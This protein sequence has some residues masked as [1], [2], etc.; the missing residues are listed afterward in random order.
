[1]LLKFNNAL[2]LSLVAV[3]MAGCTSPM[4]RL[5][6]PA[7][8]VHLRMDAGFDAD[9]CQWLG[10]VTGSEGHWYS[11]LFFTNDVM[12]QGAMND[13]KNR[14]KKLGANT[15]FVTAPQDFTTSFTVMGSAYQC[16]NKD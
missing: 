14:A 8:A 1:M 13:I 16:S 9:D 7:Q 4:N 5:D 6:S 3:F 15:V 11:Y 12:V 10:E 2:T